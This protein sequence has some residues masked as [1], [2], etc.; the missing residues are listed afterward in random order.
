MKPVSYI[1]LFSLIL[2]MSCRR[3]TME[4]QFRHIDSLIQTHPDSAVSLLKGMHQQM[5]ESSEDVK[6]Y[7]DLLYIKATDKADCMAPDESKITRLVGYFEDHHC[8]HLPEALYYA[9]RTYRELGDAPQARD[10]FVKTIEVLDNSHYAASDNYYR[11]KAYSQLGSVFIYQDMYE[12]SAAMYKK[13]LE[14]SRAMKDTMG[15]VY[16][17]R[18]LSNAYYCMNRASTSTAYALKAKRLIRKSSLD[19][20]ILDKELTAML[21]A[22]AFACG[23]Y[24]EAKKN[25]EMLLPSDDAQILIEAYSTSAPLYQKLGQEEESMEA[26]RYL[27]AHGNLYDKLKAARIM[28]DWAM[29]RQRGDA[30]PLMERTLALNDSV[31]R[32]RKTETLMRM[33]A[34]YNYNNKVKE[35]M[36]LRNEKSTYRFCMI[37]AVI[38]CLFLIAGLLFYIS[39]SRQ[40]QQLMRL[41]LE[42]YQ[43]LIEE[44]HHKQTEVLRQEQDNVAQSDIYRRIRRLLNTPNISVRLSDEDWN[45]LSELLEKTFPLF[46]K[47]LF[48]LCKLNEHEYHVSMLIK[49]GLAPSAIATLTL[50]SRESVT[51]TRRR[52][53]EKAFGKKATPKDWDDIIMSL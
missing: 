16:N 28:T 53:Y 40:R 39:F 17:L 7:Y 42:H 4:P 36:L 23:R 19:F 35:N 15:M 48:D 18:D 43:K 10:F 11:C 29:R 3:N 49:I 32:Q 34:A 12:E 9:G 6:N 20:G 21:A 31:N 51:A 8:E 41:K 47:R 26:C 25:V 2:F 46:H 22:S 1:L 27:M 37:I 24:R 45:Q 5:E 13:S 44:K 30:Y 38:L 14:I 52:L 33:N 50:H